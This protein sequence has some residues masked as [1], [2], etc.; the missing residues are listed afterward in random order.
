MAR[1]GRV[2]QTDEE[3]AGLVAETH[4]AVLAFGHLHIPSERI[5]KH[6]KLFNISSVS[7]PGD[8]DARAKYGLFTWNGAAWSFEK[9]VVE[10]AVMRELEAYKREQPPGWENIVQTM[11]AEGCYPQR[12]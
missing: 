6:L 12:V 9:C 5:W 3:L 2:R 10:Y 7:M 4:A 8:G 1:Y 11:E